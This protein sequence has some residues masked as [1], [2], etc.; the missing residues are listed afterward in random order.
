MSQRKRGFTLVELPVVI[1]IIAVLIGLLL[2][3]L[4]KVRTAAKDVTCASNIRQL[5]TATIMYRDEAGKGSYPGCSFQPPPGNPPATAQVWPSN[6][7]IT[8][9]NAIAPYLG[10]APITPTPTMTP[11]TALPPVFICPSFL[12]WPSTYYSDYINNPGVTGG[13]DFRTGYSY[14]GDI[15]DKQDADTILQP[16]DVATK[17]RRGVLW[18]DTLGY[19][20]GG[21]WFYAHASD[22]SVDTSQ[23]YPLY[24][25]GQ[26]VGYSDGS[27]IFTPLDGRQFPGH[28]T[29]SSAHLT[30]DT[31]ATLRQGGSSNSATYYWATTDHGQ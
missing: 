3:A 23:D 10:Y 31:T 22:G 15:D 21:H 20:G 24:L 16:G 29:N 14:Y 1:G 4:N 13:Y 8:D 25:R 7:S 18:A 17:T 2:P 30:W 11:D 12:N 5:L 28:L 19:W 26:H 9:I 6:L 27:V